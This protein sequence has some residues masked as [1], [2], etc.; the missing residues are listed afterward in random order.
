MVQM[1]LLEIVYCRIDVVDNSGASMIVIMCVCGAQ[2]TLSRDGQKKY[3]CIN[4]IY[5]FITWSFIYI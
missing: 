5:F 1:S 4:F 2:Q 3:G